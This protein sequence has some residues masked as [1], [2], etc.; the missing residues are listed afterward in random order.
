MIQKLVTQPAE[1]GAKTLFVPL[2]SDPFARN[3]VLSCLGLAVMSWAHS[4]VHRLNRLTSLPLPLEYQD[5]HRA[6]LPPFLPEEEAHEY[7]EAITTA[8]LEEEEAEDDS[9]S[10]SASPSPNKSFPFM[11]Q[12]NLFWDG[13]GSSGNKLLP[14]SNSLQGTIRAWRQMRRSRMHERHNAHRI[15][16]MDQLIAI[17]ALKKSAERRRKKSQRSMFRATSNNSS[18]ASQ[19]SGSGHSES[20]QPLGYAVV[21]GASRGIGRAIAVELSRWGIPLILVARD[22]DRLTSLAFDIEA[23]YGVDCCVLQADL[24]KPGVA[25]GVYQT[26]RE[27]GLPVDILVK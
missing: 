26:I 8:L 24:S 22:I 2:F 3:I 13:T 18:Q 1:Q 12:W 6:V 5:I 19:H 23:C 14:R 16:V 11:M 4:Q 21:T 9:S 10:S 7:L 15:T 25:A 17:Q 27:A 20:C